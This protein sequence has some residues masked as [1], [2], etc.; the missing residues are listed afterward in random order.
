MVIFLM[1]NN[2]KLKL[3]SVIAVVFIF[4]F[5]YMA[6]TVL[7]RYT[8]NYMTRATRVGDIDYKQSTLIG[9]KSLCKADGIDSCKVTVV[10]A[11]SDGLGI[12]GKIVKLHGLSD[13]KAVSGNTSDKLGMVS[14][15]ISSRVEG[16][17]EMKAEVD[18]KFIEKKVVLTFRN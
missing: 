8:V 11:D 5:Y 17:F 1:K 16:Q 3:Y 12:S 4:G 2:K 14:Y 6:A 10:L 13:I 18:G 9:A 15:E 7:P